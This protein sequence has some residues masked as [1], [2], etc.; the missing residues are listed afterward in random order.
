MKIIFKIC[1]G[2]ALAIGCSYMFEQEKLPDP[3]PEDNIYIRY[4]TD[5]ETKPK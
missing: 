4:V 2:T 5:Q 3:M 1:L